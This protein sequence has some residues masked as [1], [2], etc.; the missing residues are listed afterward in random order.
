MSSKIALAPAEIEERL[1]AAARTLRRLPDH[2]VPGYRSSWPEVVHD[3]RQAYGYDPARMPRIAPSP[4]D[5]SEMEEVFGWLLWLDPDD[6]RIVW[7]RAEGVR[8]KPICHRVGMSRGGAWRRWAAA[9]ITISNRIKKQARSPSKK[10][11]S[12]KA[13]DK[14]ASKQRQLGV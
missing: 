13:A 14:G 12:K 10:A 9:L 5:I 3:A 7:L 1:E 11:V 6:A 4:Q 2:H 8:W